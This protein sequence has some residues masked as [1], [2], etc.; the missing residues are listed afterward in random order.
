MTVVILALSV[1]A[2]GCSD[3][4]GTGGTGG[5]AGAGGMGGDAGAGGMGGMGGEGGTGG[6]IGTACTDEADEGILMEPGF[7]D[8]YASC[9]EAASG[10][11]AAT[12]MCLQEDTGLSEGCADCFGDYTTCLLANCIGQCLPPNQN[13][14]PCMMCLTDNCAPG[15]EDC[16]GVE[17]PSGS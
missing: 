10:D 1:S 4:E 17:F 16:A 3:D 8:D 9:A 15:F 6:I 12:S 13:S 5:D 14:E 7:T 11:G 2:W